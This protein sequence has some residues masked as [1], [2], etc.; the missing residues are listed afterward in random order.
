[1]TVHMTTRTSGDGEMLW[2]SNGPAQRKAYPVGRVQG[3]FW[4]RSL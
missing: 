4:G 3:R 1:M 2:E